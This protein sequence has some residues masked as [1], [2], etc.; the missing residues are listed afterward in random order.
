[1]KRQSRPT[2]SGLSGF[3]MEGLKRMNAGEGSM[4]SGLSTL[5]DHLAQAI[6]ALKDNRLRTG[7]SILGIM[8]GIASVMAVGTVS[9]GGHHLIFRELET[10]GLNSIWIWRDHD[11]KDPNRVVRQGSGMDHD[12]YDAIRAGCCPAVRRVSPLIFGNLGSSR[13]G[14]RYSNARVKG[15]GYQYTAMNNDVMV[16]GRPFREADA[17]RRRSV[18]ILGPTAR[19]DLFGNHQNP[20]G[21]EVYFGERKFTVVGVL[22]E[23]SRDFL[24][25]IGS[26]GGMDANNRILIPYT[27]HQKLIGH[28]DFNG[29]QIEAVGLDQVD[30]A[31]EQITRLM[32][33][34][35]KGQYR[36]RVDKMAQYIATTNRILQGV[37]L[38]GIVAASIS[39]LVGGLGIMNIMST[40]VLERTR[41]IGL[42]KAIGAR[43]RDILFQF[44][45]EAMLISTIGGLLGLILGAVASIG[46][47]FWTGFPLAPSWLTVT[48][49]LL[50][51][52]SV[53]LLSGFY[54]AR[55]AAAMRPVEA[56]RYE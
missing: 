20:I 23:K 37:S 36:Y 14:N 47:A 31:A 33:R 34:H 18:A 9:K 5:F 46:L 27:T 51:S 39:L 7:L 35:H 52:I 25:S 12:D 42:R 22:K 48:I 24:A 49:A 56:L 54:P 1:M 30:L 50:V 8:V 45:M 2:Q 10:F 53:G 32:R 44:L 16:F 11:E 13:V 55:R 15:V 19:A 21:K 28:K 4:I 17:L 40:S 3:E 6:W 43:P 26:V 29:L 38:I 41:E